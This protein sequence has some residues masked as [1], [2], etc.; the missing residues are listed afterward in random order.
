MLTGHTRQID[1]I[2]S[3]LAIYSAEARGDFEVLQE[4]IEGHVQL[5][6]YKRSTRERIGEVLAHVRAAGPNELKKRI[7]RCLNPQI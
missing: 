7:E 3:W 1:L 4:A 6:G 2:K 5:C